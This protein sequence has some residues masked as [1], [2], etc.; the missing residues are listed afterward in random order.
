MD[1]VACT[2]DREVV[3]VQRSAVIE[4]DSRSSMMEGVCTSSSKRAIP[5]QRKKLRLQQIQDKYKQAVEKLAG[6]PT[7]PLQWFLEEA[8]QNSKQ[9]D[10]DEAA[11][12]EFTSDEESSVKHGDST[13]SCGLGEAPEEKLYYRASSPESGELYPSGVYPRARASRG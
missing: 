12:S 5:Q 10:A 7:K 4:R 2:G 8:S 3:A 6:P 13:G 11:M 1:R 9:V